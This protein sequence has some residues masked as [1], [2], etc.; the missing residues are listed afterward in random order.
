MYQNARSTLPEINFIVSS[1]RYC[2]PQGGVD[3]EREIRTILQIQLVLYDTGVAQ[4]EGE[5][6][7][8]RMK[9]VHCLTIS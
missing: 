7:R 4:T 5:H 8:Y 3:A 6:N 1:V 2:R 9:N